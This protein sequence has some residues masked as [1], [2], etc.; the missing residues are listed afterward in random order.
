MTGLP[1][2]DAVLRAVVEHDGGHFERL[3]RVAIG[4]SAVPSLI[5]GRVDAVVSI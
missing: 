3:R 1:S 5:A 4:F 2:D